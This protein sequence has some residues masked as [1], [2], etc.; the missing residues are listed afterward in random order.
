M[1]GL[2]NIYLHLFYLPSQRRWRRLLEGD[3]GDQDASF[4]PSH[5]PKY[6]VYLFPGVSLSRLTAR[7]FLENVT[8]SQ[9]NRVIALSWEVGASVSSRRSLRPS[10]AWWGLLTSHRTSPCPERTRMEDC[11]PGLQGPHQT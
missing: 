7:K 10:P 2:P 8:L 1:A 9:A 4:L 3:L 11:W 5:Y 6:T